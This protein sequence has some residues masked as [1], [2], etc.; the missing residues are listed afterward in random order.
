MR[1]RL[2]YIAQLGIEL[3]SATTQVISILFTLAGELSSIRAALSQ[4]ERPLNGEHEHFLLEDPTGRLF[5]VYLRTV[6]SWEGFEFLLADR[7]KGKKGAR[8]ILRKRYVL[9]ERATHR[10][11]DRSKDWDAAFLPYQRVDM[12]LL[13]REH[14]PAPSETAWLSSCPRCFT[15]NS[16]YSSGGESQCQ[17]CNM[18]YQRVLEL[19]EEDKNESAIAVSGEELGNKSDSTTGSNSPDLDDSDEEDVNGLVRVVL[20]NLKT[21][22][23]RMRISRGSEKKFKNIE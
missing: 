20:V 19:D 17:N 10:K 8:R 4:L 6:T 7:L 12:S 18:H 15:V 22:T 21:F 5:P 1:S 9:K 14:L 11:V 23:P 13:C 2:G 3:K 16:S